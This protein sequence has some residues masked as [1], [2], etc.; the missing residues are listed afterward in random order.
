MTNKRKIGKIPESFKSNLIDI[1]VSGKVYDVSDDVELA[2]VDIFPG[3][4]DSRL[5]DLQMKLH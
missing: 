1:R 5:H 2:G 4:N 3:S